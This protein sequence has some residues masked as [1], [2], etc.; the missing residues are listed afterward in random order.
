MDRFGLNA[1]A[2]MSRAWFSAT[3]LGVVMVAMVWLGV[4]LKH[5]E[6]RR[7]DLSNAER[8]TDN[9]ALMFEEN[10]LRS[11][12]EMDKALLYLRRIIES[13]QGRPDFGAIVNARE[14]SSD[15]IMQVSIID[16]QGISRAANAGPQPSP[17]IDLSDREHFRFH[18]D[19][20]NDQLFISKPLI[21]RASGKWSVQFTRRFSNADGGF[22][23]VVVASFDPNQFAKFYSKVNLGPT[24]SYALVGTDGVVRA[25][26]GYHG[27]LQYDLGEVVS[28]TPL[29][30]RLQS[31]QDGAFV[32]VDP[33]TQTSR[34]GAL[35][36]IPGL[37]LAIM[38]SISEAGVYSESRA[39][40]MRYG[41][42]G[43]W[44]TLAIGAA[45]LQVRKA[46]QQMRLKARQLQLTLEHMSQ[47]I[48][49]VTSDLS[50]P[51]MNGKCVE[52][53]D[54]P[55]EFVDKSPTFA[56]LAGL[57]ESRGEFAGIA[58]PDQ[59][60]PLDV[61]GPRDAT[62]QFDRYERVRPNGT[63]L[64]VR[65][66]RLD[67]GGFVRTFA[68]VTTRMKAQSEA[69][70]IASQDVLT[71]L[72]N[73]RVLNETLER[74]THAERAAHS[75][76]FAI[77]CLD[78]DRF[79][80]VNDT[81]GHAVGDLL[82]KAVAKRMKQVVRAT[83]LVARLG[84]D[85]FAVLMSPL[86]AEA[87]PDTVAKRLVETLSRPY[88]I[89]GHQLL[90]GA[91]VG[92][93]I[94]PADGATANEV[95]IAGDLALY[96]AKAAGRGTHRF[97]DV[98]MNAEIRERQRIETDLREALRSE[99]LELYYQPLVRLA[100]R[101]IVG[102]E[103]LAR[104]N[105]PQHGFVPPDKFIP[106][107]EECGLIEML[108][109][110]ALRQACRQAMQWPGARRVAVNLSPAQ[111]ASPNLTQ[112]VE[113]ILAET[114]L[115]AARLELEITEGLL[116]R[117]SQATLDTLHRLKTL[118]VRIAMDDFGTGYSSLSY[119]QSF[120]FDKIKVDRSFVSGVGRLPHSS[121]VV[122]A[123][124]DIASA[125]GMMTTAEGVETE[126]QCAALLALGCTEAQGYLFGRPQQAA[127][128][129]KLIEA[130]DAAD[131]QAA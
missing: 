44:L 11:V 31:G 124:I 49:M 51:I 100:D 28:G 120:P 86:G 67:D 52:L 73:R 75:A 125:L 22:G 105:H 96:A 129:A 41:L 113:R 35:R 55:P 3:V 62:G 56:A 54:L 108:G 102:F 126:D 26:G 106:I 76:P 4:A 68:D 98:K 131:R 21:G 118:G 72:A 34:L 48:M 87:T 70:R 119:L 19:N 40:L 82:L 38:V 74:L 37:P 110:W 39:N 14:V 94:W 116:M 13:T 90:I 123:V 15:L 114:G 78:L 20:D 104:W 29:M 88:V 109:E 17:P 115:P 58:L 85:E 2:R 16:A 63:V 65:S 101:S 95:L 27:I 61:F 103:A 107:A 66:A 91:S 121:T 42:A 81:H 53:L 1:L 8:S 24:A 83:D 47:G 45:T 93:A 6:D 12:G 50:I 10:T 32:D 77:L 92:I 43:L 130:G 111:F 84:G 46:E 33:V 71:G 57:L 25:V 99:Q 128:A 127:D 23:G 30:T 112:L 64:E 117:N 60:T 9:L 5:V 89:E 79:K 7:N 69:E 80:A 97:F 18:L 122:R 59:L 36:R